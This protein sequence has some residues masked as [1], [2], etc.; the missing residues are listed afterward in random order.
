MC[1][2]K[3]YVT[4]VTIYIYTYIHT[5]IHTYTMRE[6][7]LG[8]KD[9]RKLK[10][11]G[12][13]GFLVLIRMPPLFLTQKRPIKEQ[14]DLLQHISVCS[15]SCLHYSSHMCD[16]CH[17]FFSRRVRTRK[18]R[19]QGGP[20]VHMPLEGKRGRKKKT[21]DLRSK[22]SSLTSARRHGSVLWMTRGS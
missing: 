22:L 16:I 13:F 12:S 18:D 8:H 7:V 10:D 19:S 14:K 11:G 6:S 17:F 21:L 5:Y 1:I 4:I 15:F 2:A 9:G 20:R 3:C